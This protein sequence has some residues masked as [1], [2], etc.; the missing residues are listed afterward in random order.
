V[1]R[2]TRPVRLIYF[3]LLR[4][5]RGVDAE[6]IETTAET[7]RALYREMVAAHGFSLPEDRVGVAIN[8]EFTS[9]DRPLAPNDTVV[10]IPPVAG[11]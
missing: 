3:A 8:D 4:E 10:F 2:T 11:G 9:W 6:T 5:E 7:P 1:E